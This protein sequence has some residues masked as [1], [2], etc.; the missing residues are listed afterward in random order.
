MRFHRDRLRSITSKTFLD[1]FPGILNTS[2][3]NFTSKPIPTGLSTP[4]PG[5]R[6]H[7]AFVNWIEV[8]FREIFNVDRSD[9][10]PKFC[11]VLT[12]CRC[13]T[14]VRC[15]VCLCF[16]VSAVAHVHRETLACRSLS[17]PVTSVCLHS[18]FRGPPIKTSP[19]SMPF[20]T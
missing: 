15:S 5:F 7:G 1:S 4:A 13:C 9:T 20:W 3:G 11:Q 2:T 10:D 16:S 19:R 6:F 14:C 18:D 12:S 8:M 17:V